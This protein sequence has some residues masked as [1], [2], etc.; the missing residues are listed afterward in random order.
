MIDCRTCSDL[1]ALRLEGAISD[2]QLD[3]LK[4]H[5]YGCESCR[6]EFESLRLVEGIVQDAISSQTSAEQASAKVLNQLLPLFRALIT[7]FGNL[8]QLLVG[9]LEFLHDLRVV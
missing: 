3:E 1:I 7:D 9:Q 6:K 8:L 2:T 4:A 5:T